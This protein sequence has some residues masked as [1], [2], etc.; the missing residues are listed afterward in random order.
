MKVAGYDSGENA[1]YWLSESE[2]WIS[3]ESQAA[4]FAPKHAASL[5][6]KINTM[7]R[8]QD[9]EDRI[10]ARVQEVVK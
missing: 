2:T 1:I 4:D 6:Q 9:P 10:I 3:D 7:N 8:Y 5:V